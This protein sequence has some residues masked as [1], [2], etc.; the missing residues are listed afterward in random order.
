MLVL[1]LQSSSS[2]DERELCAQTRAI[3]SQSLPCCHFLPTTPPA[4]HLPGMGNAG[5]KPQIVAFVLSSAHLKGFSPEH[6]LKLDSN[7]S[8]ARFLGIQTRIPWPQIK[9]ASR[10]GLEA[11]T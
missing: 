2:D 8:T 1:T 6:L 5:G 7:N 11:Q 4:K 9:K 10:D 3:A